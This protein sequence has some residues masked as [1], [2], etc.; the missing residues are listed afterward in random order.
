[1]TPKEELEAEFIKP[2]RLLEIAMADFS[3]AANNPAYQIVMNRWVERYAPGR[4]CAVCLAGSVMVGTCGIHVPDEFYSTSP[5]RY[6][7]R[8]NERMLALDYFRLGCISSAL[9]TMG[10]DGC[11]LDEYR[12]VASY[13]RRHPKG[14]SAFEDDMQKLITD[15]KYHDL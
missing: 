3:A 1:M 9:E 7:R 11:P 2:S 13:H 14:G 12:Q 4:P 5:S 10:V 15:L 8:I 6:G